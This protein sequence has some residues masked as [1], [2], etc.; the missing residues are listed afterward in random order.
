MEFLI[1][2]ALALCAVPRS[3]GLIVTAFLS[4]ADCQLLHFFALMG[5]STAALIM[6]DSLVAGAFLALA[7]AEFKKNLWLL[8]VALIGT[9]FS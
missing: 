3:S 4:D 7:V 6:L 2:A 8:V 1:G 9:A 5:S